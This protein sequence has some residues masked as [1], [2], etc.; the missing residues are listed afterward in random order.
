MSRVGLA[1]RRQGTAA[2]RGN[3]INE[4]AVSQ[5][6]EGKRR[7]YLEAHE[8]VALHEAARCEL[9]NLKM[10]AAET[11]EKAMMN[12]AWCPQ[13]KMPGLLVDKTA[14]TAALG[15]LDRTGFPMIKGLVVEDRRTTQLSEGDL[16]DR[17]VQAL[18]TLD[19]GDV[20]VILGRLLEFRPECR[21]PVTRA[22]MGPSIEV[23]AQVEAAAG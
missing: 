23:H 4:E 20:G 11:L 12:A 22:L 2:L 14:V 16:L 7:S 5:A 15:I 1:A 6:L 21:E 3:A 10:Q 8:E 9:H 13:C 18:R 17:A 19:P